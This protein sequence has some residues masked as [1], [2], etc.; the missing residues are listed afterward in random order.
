MDGSVHKTNTYGNSCMR[1]LAFAP[2]FALALAMAGCGTRPVA[3]SEGHI[4]A[5]SERPASAASIP[6]VVRQAPLPPPPQARESEIKYSVVVAN[7]PVREVL[8]AMARETRVN[9]DIHPGIEGTVNLNA[10]D[11]TLK[12]ILNRMAKQVDMRWETDGQTITVMPDTPYLHVYKVDYV[13]MSRDVAGTIGVQSQV[14]AP[15][16]AG[17][18][19]GSTSQNSSLLKVD[20][21]AKN[22]FWETLERN[23]K[24]MLRE[25]D[26]LLP[27]GSSETFVQNR[28]QTAVAS[29]QARTTT[30]PRTGRTTTTQN[31]TA[32]DSPGETQQAQNTDFVEQRLTFR[33]AA[34]V[35]VNPETGTVLVRGTSRQH[36]K[37]AEFIAQVAGS[38]QIGR[39]S[40]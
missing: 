27:E 34:S 32:V 37:V 3:K 8:F 29:T 6:Q 24:D 5:E 7:Q 19:A 23:V 16:G 40:C 30:Q 39:A 25:T 4:L 31:R 1:F 2:C 36:E 26:K 12:Q 9:F 17:A 35:I 28:G 20:N 38:A 13:N 22:H 11:Q 33:E 14:V 18:A 10:I 21:I 15:P